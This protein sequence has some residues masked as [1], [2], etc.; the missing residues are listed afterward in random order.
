M[1]ATV[2]LLFE[3]NLHVS[4]V[5]GGYL[6]LLRRRRVAV[7]LSLATVARVCYGALPVA[8]LLLVVQ[9]RAS[10]AV[11]GAILAVY[12]L[13]AGLLGPWR[14]RLV[15]RLGVLRGLLPLTLVFCAGLGAIS[16]ASHP[17]AIWMGLLTALTGLA[18]PPVGPL[19][20]VSLRAYVGGD[21]DAVRGAYAMDTAGEE[22]AFAV[23][24]ALA[25]A[26]VARAGPSLALGLCTCLLLGT[27]GGMCAVL[28]PDLPRAA[29]RSARRRTPALSALLPVVALGVLIGAFDV[30]SL[31]AV[32]DRVGPGLAG[33]PAAAVAC[34]GLGGTVVYGRLRL[35][36]HPTRHLNVLTWA[37]A[38]LAPWALAL[39]TYPG[40]IIG[41]AFALGALTSP[42]IVA[43]YLVADSL[44]GTTEGEPTAWVSAGLN[45]ALSVG[46]ALGG[47]LSP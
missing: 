18:A 27:V 2:L 4:A 46:A 30:V 1:R 11:A 20:R 12:G 7:L 25:G 8:L 17:A 39:A 19:V 41:L 45:G 35:D 23:G 3:G 34:G 16:L 24:P 5:P 40:V 47:R 14:A 33:V 38:L 21:T 9:G 15:D 6:A 26:L 29:T 28:S 43:A 10:Y 13:T 37:A 32:A 36:S 31:A 22:A 44:A 42:A